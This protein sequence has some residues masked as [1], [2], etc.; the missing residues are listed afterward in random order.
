MGR[1]Y[2]KRWNSP[3]SSRVALMLGKRRQYMEDRFKHLTHHRRLFQ[4]HHW[5]RLYSQGEL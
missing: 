5:K 1:V 2:A 3:S 4:R